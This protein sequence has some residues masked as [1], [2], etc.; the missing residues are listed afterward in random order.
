LEVCCFCVNIVGFRVGLFDGLEVQI[1]IRVFIYVIIGNFVE[2]DV[3]T[4]NK[5]GK[6]VVVNSVVIFADAGNVTGLTV[7]IFDA[8]ESIVGDS[9]GV[10]VVGL[11]GSVVLLVSLVGILVFDSIL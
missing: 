3:I 2:G 4:G 8:E 7:E 1:T 9:V 10:V 6:F 5:V 11:I